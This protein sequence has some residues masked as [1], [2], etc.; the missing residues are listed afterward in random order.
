M[1]TKTEF[2]NRWCGQFQSLLAV[3][4][5]V[6]LL[7]LAAANSP[8]QTYTI[9]HTFG[10]NVMGLN[11]RAPLV[12]GPDGVLYGT[13]SG[14]G[15]AN[16]GQVFKV[17]ADGT[18][19]TVLKDFAGDDGRYPVGGMLLAG[20]TL[21]GT[22]P[23]GGTNDNGT[24]FKVNTDG[25]GFAV[26][27]KFQGYDGEYPY[28]GLVLSDSKLYGT[29]WGGGS[30]GSG[31][32]FKVNTDGSG[33][34]LLHSFSGFTGSDNTNSDGAWPYALV[35]SD[36]TIFGTTGGGGNSGNGTV[37]K[38]N[39][40]GSGFALLHSFSRLTGPDYTNADGVGP[41]NLLLSDQTLYGTAGGGGSSDNGTVF[42]LNTDGSSFTTLKDFDGGDDGSDP[43]GL[44]QSGAT[45]YG[46][47][48]WGGG[49]DINCGTVFKIDTDGSGYAILKQFTGDDGAS[50]Y[51]GLMLSGATL[52]G[53]TYGGG[54]YGF[55]TVFK[56]GTNGSNY[57]L[58]M[59]FAGGDGASPSGNLLLSGTTLYGTTG[60][61]G[62]SG[63]GT[64]FKANIDGSGYT[65]LKD[66]TNWQEGVYPIGGPVLSG[67]KL[68]ETTDGGG[69]NGYGTVFTINTDGSGYTVLH[70]FA[71]FP[72][73]GA[74][75]ALGLVLSGTTLYGTTYNGGRSDVGTVFKV[76]TDGSGYAV[77]MDFTEDN[78][79]YPEY[80][81][82]LSGTTL[83]GTTDSGGY[84]GG[85]TV[86]TI[87]TDGSGYTELH[88][89]SG[90]PSEG[91]FPD[92]GL[93]LSGTVLYGTTR[94]GG[95]SM[96]GEVFKLNTDGSD[97]VVL[98]EFNGNEGAA[99]QLAALS[100]NGVLYGSAL[101]GGLGDNGTLFSINTN[102]ANFTVLK[103][104]NGEDGLY[105]DCGLVLSGTTLFG[106]T[107]NGG[108]LDSGV[109]FSL[110][111][112]PSL[113][114]PSQTQ[115]AED[116]CVVNLAADVTG[117]PPPTCQWFFNGNAIGGCTNSD[118]RLSGVQATNVGTYLVVV[119][120]IYGAV[121]SAPVMLNVIVPVERRPVPEVK[122]MGEAGSTL[123]L[124]Y[125]ESLGPVP[126]W[127][128]LNM[129]NLTNPPQYVF[130]VTLS[131]PPQRFYRAWQSGT[132]AVVPLLNL[133][134][135]PAITLTG[136]AGNQLR[137]DYINQYGPTDAWVTL[138]T[139]TLTNTSQL[140]FDVSSIGQPARLYRIVPV[141]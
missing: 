42:K 62:S 84:H 118:L 74:G 102:G 90:G 120:N 59:S 121:T 132:P 64:I 80:G 86:F 50:P 100:T 95:S 16:H 15:S 29:T 38:V 31:T 126:N 69:S 10:T 28:A 72:S 112:L 39:T 71:G 4:A 83:Y 101:W 73:D 24:V 137:L 14:G 68:Y 131:L 22:T 105:P 104:F 19:Y 106:T 26:L 8:A 36:Q 117:F 115:T 13:T 134:M 49:I 138:D 35:L 44:V 76:N 109:L 85:G 53:T 40:D 116:G 125:A 32:F 87:N 20:S 140:Y 97:F 114:L 2:K 60:S 17:N 55:G 12:Q 113:L 1:N 57:A 47:T 5:G 81:L 135:V 107:G 119:S 136:S 25:T 127:L 94:A 108:S 21:Y 54:N 123:N 18:G 141:P 41:G 77:L 98:K 51:A 89:F 7:C 46:T 133:H 58:L 75:P 129:V 96:V 91:A 82:V 56:V 139:V 124:E 128:P 103:D 23:N 63:N 70:S 34:A 6:L 48:A 30:F 9:L 61:G 37:F 130:D 78:G 122:L 43:I 11:P 66:F 99:P 45:L 92:A 33:F 27:K 111:L 67:T 79:R 65:V 52:V 93:V 110:S 88:S 3:Q